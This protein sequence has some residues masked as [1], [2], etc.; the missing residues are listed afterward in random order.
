[1]AELKPCPFCGGYAH[2]DK[3]YSY[4]RDTVIYCE[5][6]DCVFTL[7]DRSTSTEEIVNAWNKRVPQTV[8]NQHGEN[9]THIANCGTLN[10]NL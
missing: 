6:C 2:L 7:D 1:M 8:V 10:L 3:A 9:C 4:F 5:G